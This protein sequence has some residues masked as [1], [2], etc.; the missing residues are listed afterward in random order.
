MCVIEL[1]TTCFC[2]D[3]AQDLINEVEHAKLGTWWTAASQPP[4]IT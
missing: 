2:V 3:L 4:S 1:Q